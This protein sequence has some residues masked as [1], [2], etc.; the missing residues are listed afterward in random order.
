MSIYRHHRP[1]RQYRP[2]QNCRCPCQEDY[3]CHCCCRQTSCH[4]TTNHHRT[5]RPTNRPRSHQPSRPHRGSRASSDANAE[6]RPCR[7]SSPNGACGKYTPPCQLHR[8]CRCLQP[9]CR[10]GN[11]S[12]AHDGPPG[13][14]I[15]SRRNSFPSPHRSSGHARCCRRMKKA[16]KQ[17]ILPLFGSFTTTSLCQHFV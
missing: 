9:S 6:A 17:P 11:G 4:Q 15:P 7:V 10:S 2:E 13:S 5:C 3:R 8:Q 12:R 14:Y 1:N 16:M